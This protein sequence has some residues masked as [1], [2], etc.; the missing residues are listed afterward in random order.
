MSLFR[1]SR[2]RF[3]ATAARFA[4]TAYLL[5]F[6]AWLLPSHELGHAQ[7]EIAPQIAYSQVTGQLH[8]IGHDSD[9]CQLCRAHA[10]YDVWLIPTTRLINTAA[11]SMV[12]GHSDQLFGADFPHPLSPR[13]PPSVA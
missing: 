2:R 11:T 7:Q 10:Q 13:A 4:A 1:S 6:F 9:R 12:A 5:F 8:Q 3:A